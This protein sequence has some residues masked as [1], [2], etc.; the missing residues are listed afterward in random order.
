MDHAAASVETRRIGAG[1]QLATCVAMSTLALTIIYFQR[2]FG[3][4]A[5]LAHTSLAG[6]AG[7]GLAIGA[8]AALVSHLLFK[9]NEQR[10]WL[11]RT[12]DGYGRMIDLSGWNVLWFSLAAGVGEEL[13]FRAALQPVL[14]LWLSSLV[15]MLIHAPGYQF[16]MRDRATLVQVLVLLSIS[17]LLGLVFAHIGLVAAMIVHAMIDL[18]GLTNLRRALAR[19]RAGAS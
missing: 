15:F 13:L 4:Q 1:I 17:V 8:A 11:R 3:M 9:L 7:A 14:G 2:Q 19:R 10:A 18:V 5:P 16:R 12:I 6:Q